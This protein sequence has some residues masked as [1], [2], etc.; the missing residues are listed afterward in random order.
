MFAEKGIAPP[1]NWEELRAVAK[2][3][4]TDERFGFG[5]TPQVNYYLPFVA[6]AGGNFV[7]ENGI[8]QL[9]TE[10]HAK[11]LQLL[12]DLFVN[13]KSASS[14]QMVGAGW[15]GEMFAK[16]QVAMVYGGSWITGVLGS[17]E[18]L[19]VGIVPMPALN[20]EA[21]MLFTAGWVISSKSE[22]PEA[23]MDFIQFLS[24]DDELVTGNQVGL[25]GLPPTMSGMQ[26]LMEAKQDDPF[27][28]TYASIVKNGIP[29]GWLDP[30]LVDQYNKMLEVLLYKPDTTT[31]E[32]SLQDLQ[33]ELQ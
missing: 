23:A 15:D 28:S 29:F 18:G 30:K 14:P 27:L 7:S 12:V 9:D 13:D 33:K 2:A 32:K 5:I 8:G 20:S 21:S 31:P 11:A 16:K 19:D 3:L 4:T 22:H 6:S 24:S 1:T 25:I 26:K 10:G 17:E